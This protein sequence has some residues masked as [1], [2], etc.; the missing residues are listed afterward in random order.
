MRR[1]AGVSDDAGGEAIAEEGADTT[2]G[3]STEIELSPV[4]YF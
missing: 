4:G 2:A 3:N 1:G